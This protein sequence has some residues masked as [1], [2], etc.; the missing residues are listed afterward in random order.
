MSFPLDP[1]S[2]LDKYY[3]CVEWVVLRVRALHGDYGKRG[4]NQEGLKKKSRLACG[5]GSGE[6]VVHA[7][8]VQ[9]NIKFL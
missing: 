4:K 3:I 9:D 5:G 7:L 2:D 8:E 6:L 1:S